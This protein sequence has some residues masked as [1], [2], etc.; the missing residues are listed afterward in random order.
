MLS[1]AHWTD[2]CWTRSVEHRPARKTKGRPPRVPSKMRGVATKRRKAAGRGE[3]HRRACRAKTRTATLVSTVRWSH[4]AGLRKYTRCRWRTSST[5][6]T[7][8][9]WL[10]WN[11]SAA[12]PF[13]PPNASEA[14]RLA[15]PSSASLNMA[16]RTHTSW[17]S[18]AAWG[19]GCPEVVCRLKK[20]ALM[21]EK[22]RGVIGSLTWALCAT[23]HQTDT[24]KGGRVGTAN[25]RS[26]HP[27]PR[28]PRHECS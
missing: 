13:K 25:D 22:V 16:I 11:A 28:A 6:S 5:I 15:T 17:A 26:T 14:T 2:R 21:W 1:C 12:A 8:P 19:R 27:A 23:T 4:M 10:L 20:K 7:S 3:G 9:E 18:E 24:Q